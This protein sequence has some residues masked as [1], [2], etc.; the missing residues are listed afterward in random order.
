MVDGRDKD[1]DEEGGNGSSGA[2]GAGQPLIPNFGGRRSS[3]ERRSD[4][5]P[6]REEEPIVGNQESYSDMDEPYVPDVNDF[7]NRETLPNGFIL[8]FHDGVWYLF[9]D[10]ED[11]IGTFVGREAAVDRAREM[12]PFP[13][14]GMRF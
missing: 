7:A 3:H 1:D 5:Q 12:K 8:G 4:P 11:F 13:G 10:K 6:S 14:S 9:N 2:A